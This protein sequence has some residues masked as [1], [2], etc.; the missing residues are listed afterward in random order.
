MWKDRNCLNNSISLLKLTMS[1]ERFSRCCYFIM[2]R[3]LYIWIRI[4]LLR[5]EFRRSHLCNII[6]L[7]REI[8]VLSILYGEGKFSY[9]RKYGWLLLTHLSF[10]NYLI[11]FPPLYIEFCMRIDGLKMPALKISRLFASLRNPKSLCVFGTQPSTLITAGLSATLYE[12]R[13]IVCIKSAFLQYA[14]SGIVKGALLGLQNLLAI[15]I[16]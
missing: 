15:T 14:A 5:Y 3:V 6:V 8:K 9:Q 2:C 7:V 12:P 13:P 10:P 4:T 1:L 16:A 11:A